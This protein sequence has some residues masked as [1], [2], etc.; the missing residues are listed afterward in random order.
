MRV[1]LAFDWLARSEGM[2]PYI[3]SPYITHCSFN[4]LFLSFIPSEPKAS[5]GLKS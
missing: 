3:S 2:D 4:F 1:E 5:L